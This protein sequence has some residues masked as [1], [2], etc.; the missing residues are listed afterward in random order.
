MELAAR[1]L[2]PLAIAALVGLA[3]GG[4]AQQTVTATVDG[5]L[6]DRPTSLPGFYEAELTVTV[7]VGGDACLCTETHVDPVGEAAEAETIQIEPDSYTITWADQQG[8]SHEQA[9]NASIQLPQLE[10]GPVQAT[11]DVEMSHEPNGDHVSS[12]TEPANLSLPV[13]EPD[14]QGNATTSGNQTQDGAEPASQEE[15]GNGVP[16]PG[17]AAAL[18]ATLAAAGLRRHS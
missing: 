4:L 9:V 3:G 17:A 16:A 5:Q 2:A 1:L 10:E 13:P 8:G 6:V 11:F 14:P 7:E 12:N 15:S 18:A